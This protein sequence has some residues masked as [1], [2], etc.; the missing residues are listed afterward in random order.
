[1]FPGVEVTTGPL[2]QGISNAVGIAIAEKHLSAVYNKP[3]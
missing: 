1:L 2:G 3:N